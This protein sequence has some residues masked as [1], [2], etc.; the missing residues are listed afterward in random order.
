MKMMISFVLTAIFF[1]GIIA[2]KDKDKKQFENCL[3]EKNKKCIDEVIENANNGTYQS[4]RE[5]MIKCCNNNENNERVVCF[6]RK[7]QEFDIWKCIQKSYDCIL[8]KLDMNPE[9]NK[10]YTEFK[11]TKQCD[12][13]IDNLKSN[14]VERFCINYETNDGDLKYA[15]SQPNLFA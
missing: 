10:L 7:I 1:S 4:L 12:E 2:A 13:Y 5:S 14:F 9:L 15:C 3:S 8:N 11:E 6:L